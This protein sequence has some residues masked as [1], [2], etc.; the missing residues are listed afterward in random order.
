[1]A[2]SGLVSIAR[3]YLS[4]ASLKLPTLKKSLPS[5]FMA[6]GGWQHGNRDDA[7]GA[8][9]QTQSARP[10]EHEKG[11][12]ARLGSLGRLLVGHGGDGGAQRE[13]QHAHAF[14]SV[15]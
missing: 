11:C 14:S 13:V 15:S 6:C 7:C 4:S 10:L 3:L 2:I 9:R 12:A 1:M 5:F 8:R